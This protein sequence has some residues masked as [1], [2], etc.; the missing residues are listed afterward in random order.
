MSKRKK[1]KTLL[2]S[3]FILVVVGL[4]LSGCRTSAVYNVEKSSIAAKTTEDK[5]FEAIKRAG[6]AKGWIITKVK[7]GLA[8][9]KIALRKHMATVEIPY[10]SKSF[11]I[12][13][14]N[15]MNLNYDSTKGTIHQNYNGWIQNLENAIAV[16]LSML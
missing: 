6:Y 5:V 3:L 7:P 16:E 13:Y 8:E 9:G 10:S 15:S 12:V 14:K 2:K 1:M 11:S 4:V